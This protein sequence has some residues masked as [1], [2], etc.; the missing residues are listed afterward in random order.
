LSAVT[1][2]VIENYNFMS[3]TMAKLSGD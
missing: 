2:H 3:Q 1:F